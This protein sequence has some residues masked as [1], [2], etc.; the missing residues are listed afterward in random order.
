MILVSIDPGIHIAGL[1]IW[2]DA[3]LIGAH[4]VRTEKD[5]GGW[6]KTSELVEEAIRELYVPIDV[7]VIEKPQVYTQRK[8]KGDPN[9]LIDLACATGAIARGLMARNHA[10]LFVIKPHRWK[11]QTPKNISV[12]RS[13]AALEPQEKARVELPKARRLSH[14]I[15]DAIGIGLYW[16]RNERRQRGQRAS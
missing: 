14:N 2:Q 13:E 9:D 12:K 1:A 7:I 10:E 3:E 8:L 15:W 16:L 11:G 5:A 6:V 4:L